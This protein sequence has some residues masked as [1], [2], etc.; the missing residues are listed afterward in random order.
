MG[1]T[2]LEKAIK[3]NKKAFKKLMIENSK[4]IYKLAY[5]HTKYE[6]DAK[7]I[8]ERSVT[9]AW[10]NIS[11]FSKYDSFEKYMAKITIKHI[12]E[13]LED[14]GMVE[15]NNN[16]YV[17]KDG[18][19][20]IFEGVDLLDINSKNVVILIYF[21]NLSYEDVGNI[22]NMNESTVK[23]YFRN[24]LRFMIDSIKGDITSNKLD[25]D[26]LKDI[27]FHDTEIEKNIDEEIN[28]YLKKFSMDSSQLNLI[29]IPNN[30]INSVELPF[31]KEKKEKRKN[32]AYKILDIIIVSIILLPMVG[33]WYPKVFV[34]VPEV[35]DIFENINKFIQVDNLKSLM[36]L[37][38]EVIEGS[39]SV[40]KET[41]YIKEKDIVKPTNNNG[42]IKLIHSLANTLVEADYKWQCGEVTPKT[43]NLALK[44]VEE[45]E[46]HYDR[47][48]L[49]NSLTK[50]KNG[51]FSNAVEVHNY[52]WE[53]LDGSVGK[54]ESLDKDKIQEILN[55]YY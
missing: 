26:I 32:I 29:S 33:V 12:N 50:W 15:G 31:K 53:M 37:E 24:S 52:V 54:A 42:A 22:L 11:K 40:S 41:I 36:G 5:I 21:Y 8:V 23:L 6:E 51:E 9:Y 10:D 2:L 1:L 3:G 39:E 27:Y 43:I 17:N 46:D 7:H 19:I 55:K 25:N 20:N 35:Y 13:Y 47:M 38:K 14:V 49:R 44:G 28:E 45:I 48:H 16:T 34:K 30:I 18:L 4:D